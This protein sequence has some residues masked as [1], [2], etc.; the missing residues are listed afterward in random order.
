M[1][2]RHGPRGLAL[3]LLVLV[4]VRVSPAFGDARDEARRHFQEGMSLI[5]AGNFDEGTAEL[6]EAYRILPHPAVLYNI[7]R[8]FYDAGQYDRAIEE[9]ERYAATEPADK[10]EVERLIETARARVREGERGGGP[11]V[12]GPV[13]GD[14]LVERR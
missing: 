11:A 2:E 1:L 6:Y 8:A 7:G 12:A 5:R 10:E 13:A 14:H 9:L 4:L 3:A